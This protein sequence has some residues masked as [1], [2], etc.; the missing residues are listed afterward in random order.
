MGGEIEILGNKD[1]CGIKDHKRRKEWK[2]ML[3]KGEGLKGV[4]IN[5]I[6]LVILLSFVIPF[7]ILISEDVR[8]SAPGLGSALVKISY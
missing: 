6:Q 1:A 3:G 5:K 2:R 8:S 4:L 7:S